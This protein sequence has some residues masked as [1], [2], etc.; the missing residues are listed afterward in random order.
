MAMNVQGHI[1]AEGFA[2][3]ELRAELYSDV[4]DALTVWRARGIK[5]YIYSSGSRHTPPLCYSAAA[6]ARIP[7]YSAIIRGP[8][9]LGPN[10]SM[11]P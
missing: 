11:F 9:G 8:T 5:T 3:G 6:W 7:C 1:W 10:S 4:A 2:K